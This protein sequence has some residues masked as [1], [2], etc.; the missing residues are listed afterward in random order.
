MQIQKSPPESQWTILK[1]L[2][3]ATSY[4]KS[5][6]IDSPRLTVEILLAHVLGVE[7]IRLYTDFDRPLNAE[8]LS[9][10][11]KL[12]K[13]R[14]NREPVAYIIGKKEFFALE[15]S[16]SPDV[17]IPRPETEFL[18]EEALRHLPEEGFLQPMKIIDMGTG[19]GVIIV[20]IAANR[21]GHQFF[22]SDASFSAIQIAK[23]NAKKNALNNIRFF[24]G[25]WFSTLNPSECE[26]DMIVSNP[27][28]IPAGEVEKLAPE[29]SEYEPK[30][31][32]QAGVD[33]MKE[34]QALIASA[35]DYLKTNGIMMLEIGHDQ[36][37][38]VEEMILSQSCWR[39]EK[40]IKDY[41]GHDRVAV[42][43]KKG[44]Q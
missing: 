26:F 38:R 39:L 36:R 32:L 13:R 28:Y 33:G 22:A 17:L 2:E 24:A 8:E 6:Q 34:I 1:I 12:I 9:H 43:R 11:K 15:F 14:L 21:P 3:W 10:L 19:S 41:G 29:I 31:A 23:A 30:S 40:F 20:S 35:P 7:R 27:P 44:G 42:M 4:F 16:V 5:N 25:N 18:V 37:S